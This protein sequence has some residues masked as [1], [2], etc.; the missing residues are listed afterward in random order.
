METAT[1]TKRTFRPIAH[2][3]NLVKD[4]DRSQKLELATMLID[5]VKPAVAASMHDTTDEEDF[6][7]MKKEHLKPYTMEELHARIAQSERDAAEGRVQDFDEAMDE[8]EAEL[9]REEQLEMAE[10][11]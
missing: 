5:S 7:A 4:I 3:W 1:K 2:Y 11:I 6:P 10:A 8:I 9:A